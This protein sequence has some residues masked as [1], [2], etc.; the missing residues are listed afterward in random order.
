MKIRMAQNLC[1]LFFFT[2]LCLFAFNQS[3]LNL[4][5]SIIML[6]SVIGYEIIL[7]GRDE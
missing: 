4:I 7:K 6:A 3:L 5:C 2:N 1:M